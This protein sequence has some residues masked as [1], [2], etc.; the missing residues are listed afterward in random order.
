MWNHL[1][2]QVRCRGSSFPVIFVMV[3]LPAV[4]PVSAQNI[5]TNSNLIASLEPWTQ[6]AST[7]PD[8]SA[9]GSASWTNVFNDDNTADGTGSAWIQ[10]TGVPGQPANASIGIR[11]CVPLPLAPVDV[12]SAS[13]GAHFLA[14]A[15]GN[16]IDGLANA[17]VE[18]RFYSDA[19]CSTFIPGTGGSQ[20]YRLTSAALSDTV[21]YEIGDWNLAMP[22][23]PVVASSAEVRVFVRTLAST[24]NGY[25]V[26]FDRI[27]M[28]LN[29]TVPVELS[30]FEI[31]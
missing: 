4:A 11:Q 23:T 28:S 12:A 13:Y 29:G 3:W 15:T 1:I 2:R 7:T 22:G 19:D 18:V 16:P 14:P 9:T 31:E 6:E 20:G 21:W 8:P 30:K 17:T 24:D 25:Q 5:V 27:W 10:L 26:Y